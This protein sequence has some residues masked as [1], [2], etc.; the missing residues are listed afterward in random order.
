[1]IKKIIEKPIVL[2]NGKEKRRVWKL[3]QRVM[4]NGIILGDGAFYF[5]IPI[6]KHHVKTFRLDGGY[7][8]G[9][10]WVIRTIVLPDGNFLTSGRIF[11]GRIKCK[12]RELGFVKITP[13]LDEDF[14]WHHVDKNHVV[15]TPR[16]LHR[17]IRH[18]LSRKQ[19]MIKIN[20]VINYWYKINCGFEFLP[21][22]E[23][24]PKNSLFC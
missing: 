11:K 6:V 1:M 9:W 5:P 22:K 4:T 19:S 17:T 8:V 13:P 23:K 16:K 14:D 24:T 10:S 12:R 21:L 20:K 2:A 3:S 15:A 7:E 18:T